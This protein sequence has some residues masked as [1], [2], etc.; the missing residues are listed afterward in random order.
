MLK[1]KKCP[2]CKEEMIKTKTRFVPLAIHFMNKKNPLR[3]LAI[4]NIPKENVWFCKKCEYL[5]K[6]NV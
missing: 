6:R 1:N 4:S 2:E 3:N 5:V